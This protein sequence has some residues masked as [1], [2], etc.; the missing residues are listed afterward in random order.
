[1]TIPLIAWLM[2]CEV[3]HSSTSQATKWDIV[4]RNG[5]WSFSPASSNVCLHVFIY[6]LAAEYAI[7]AELAWSTVRLI[8]RIDSCTWANCW[9]LCWIT[10]WHMSSVMMSVVLSGRLSLSS[11]SMARARLIMQSKEFK[12][13]VWALGRLAPSTKPLIANKARIKHN[14]FTNSFCFSLGINVLHD[15]LYYENKQE[16]CRWPPLQK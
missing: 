15:T 13:R 4:W 11:A 3:G 5:P 2:T 12:P 1:M 8:K 7:S 9:R 10:S 14:M 16:N 6:V